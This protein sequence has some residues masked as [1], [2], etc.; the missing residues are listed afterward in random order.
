MDLN[1]SWDC[2]ADPGTVPVKASPA[3]SSSRYL[4]DWFRN[5]ASISSL[6][7]SPVQLGPAPLRLDGT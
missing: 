5:L 2:A 3:S 4:T 1:N 7:A 6:P